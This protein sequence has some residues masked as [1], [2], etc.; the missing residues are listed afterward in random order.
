MIDLINQKSHNLVKRGK[1]RE[2]PPPNTPL[3]YGNDYSTFKLLRA[4]L[5]AV[6]NMILCKHVMFSFEFVLKNNLLERC[7]NGLDNLK[8]HQ[9]YIT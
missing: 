7:L 1:G 8:V 3:R 5:S 9:E 6:S 4:I 2:P